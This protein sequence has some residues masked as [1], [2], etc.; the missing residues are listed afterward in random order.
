[1][2]SLIFID[3]EFDWSVEHRPRGHLSEF[4]PSCFISDSNETLRNVK[5]KEISR[6]ILAVQCL[7]NYCTCWN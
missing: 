5:V 3:P 6:D 7:E 4:F 1:M 2:M